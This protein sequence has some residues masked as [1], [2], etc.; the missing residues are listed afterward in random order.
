MMWKYN[1]LTIDRFFLC[2][3]SSFSLFFFFFFLA[4]CFSFFFLS[5][6]PFI[7]IPFIF[8]PF[9]VI[10]FIFVFLLFRLFRLILSTP[11]LSASARFFA[12][13]FFFVLLIAFLIHHY[14]VLVGWFLSDL[15]MDGL[16]VGLSLTD[17]LKQN[18]I[19]ASL[20]FFYFFY[21]LP[22]LKMGAAFCVYLKVHV[23]LY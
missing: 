17:L 21:F 13:F 2:L 18:Q 10:P 8:I 12:A 11:I 3:V 9:I 22:D 16:I 7:V 5:V 23:W 15:V 14:T 20:T 6:I 1:I 4:H 19:T